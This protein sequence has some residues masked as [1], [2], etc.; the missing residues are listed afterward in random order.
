MNVWQYILVGVVGVAS[1]MLSGLFGVGGGILIIPSLV[2]ILGFNQHEAQGTSLVALL[3][4]VGILGVIRYWKAGNVNWIAGLIIA[5]GLF[6]GAYFG[7]G[8]AN[9]INEIWLKRAFGI[10]LILAGIRFILT[11]AAP[12]IS[13]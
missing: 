4:P 13:Q 3:L 8:W 2:L 6:V 12:A 9:K 11:K 1:G 5:A 7:A 10:L